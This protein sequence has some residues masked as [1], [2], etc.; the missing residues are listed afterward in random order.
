MLTRTCASREDDSNSGP[1]RG[2]GGE[3]V[4]NNEQQA[5]LYNYSSSTHTEQKIE[6]NCLTTLVVRFHCVYS[7][8][9][10]FD[11]RTIVS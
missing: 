5:T 6:N 9:C 4:V 8:P 1:S 3:S 2:L 10:V 11:E 7:I